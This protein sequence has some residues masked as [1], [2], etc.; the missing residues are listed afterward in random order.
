MGWLDA[1]PGRRLSMH[2]GIGLGES[3]TPFLWV[4]SDYWY[5][6]QPMQTNAFDANGEGPIA[7]HLICGSKTPDGD[8]RSSSAVSSRSPVYWLQEVSNHDFQVF[9][10]WSVAFTIFTSM[11]VTILTMCIP[12]Y[13]MRAASAGAVAFAS[14]GRPN[15]EFEYLPIDLSLISLFCLDPNA[16]DQNASR[17]RTCGFIKMV[18]QRSH[19][20]FSRC[21]DDLNRR[22]HHHPDDYMRT[23][24]YPYANEKLQRIRFEHR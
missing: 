20:K 5:K 14:G 24:N 6:L 9:S 16:F 11:L 7:W 19:G 13:Y 10:A 18:C 4:Y 21:S 17:N 2:F 3:I 1:E 12:H 15:T 22:D 23:C 8:C